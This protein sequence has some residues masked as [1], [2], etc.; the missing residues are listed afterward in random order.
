MYYKTDNLNYDEKKFVS[1]LSDLLNWARQNNRQDILDEA[2]KYGTINKLTNLRNAFYTLNQMKKAENKS[3]INSVTPTPKME[4]TK[5]TPEAQSEPQAQAQPSADPTSFDPLLGANPMQRDYTSGMP[6]NAGTGAPVG[7]IP[8]PNFQGQA[9]GGFGQV[10]PNQPDQRF[11]NTQDMPQGEKNKSSLELAKMLVDAYSSN[12]PKLF[13]WM[14]KIKDSKVQALARTG[15]LEPNLILRPNNITV[16][17]YI[18]QSNAEIDKAF[19]VTPEWKAEITPVLHRV[20]EK[21]NWGVTDEQI[22]GYYIGSHLIQC[23]VVAAQVMKNNNAFLQQM[24]QMTQSFRESGNLPQQ[25][26]GGNDTPPPPPPVAPTPPPPPTDIIE[27]EVEEIPNDMSVEVVPVVGM[28]SDPLAARFDMPR[29]RRQANNVPPAEEMMDMP[30]AGH[31][32]SKIQP[33]NPNA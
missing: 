9:G 20:L 5:P 27:P 26:M 19:E 23:G 22:L 8:E 32:T 13:S 2:N 14:A 3:K 16:G 30:N 4:E 29:N 18:E 7:A 10:P 31:I 15:D 33:M 6:N 1:K 28:D 12:V 24:V 25:P 17:Q 11:A 21:R